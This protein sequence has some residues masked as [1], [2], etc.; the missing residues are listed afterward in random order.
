MAAAVNRVALR[1]TD[2]VAAPK[3]PSMRI[4]ALAIIFAGLAIAGPIPTAHAELA[5]GIRAIV[6][7]AIITYEEVESLIPDVVWR[8]FRNQPELLQKKL[9]QLRNENLEIMIEHQLILHEFKTAGYNLPESVIEDEVQQRIH[10][11]YSDRTK[12]TKTLQSE[13][14]TYEK[15]KQQIREQ[16]IVGALRQK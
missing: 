12:L 6:H 11:K 9:E 15:F 10:D 8:Q 5:N 3:L 2:A 7:D 14:M 4:R 16:F 1:L 13:G